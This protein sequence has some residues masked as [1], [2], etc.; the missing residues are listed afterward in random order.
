MWKLVSFMSVALQFLGL[1]FTYF[2]ILYGP[3]S[4]YAIVFTASYLLSGMLVMSY[5]LGIE[6]KPDKDTRVGNCKYIQFSFYNQQF[7]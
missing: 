2:S 1:V 3:I 5:I 6:E 4:I 7:L